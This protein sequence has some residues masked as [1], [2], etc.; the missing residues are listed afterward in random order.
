MWTGPDFQESTTVYWI[1]HI[2]V[3]GNFGGNLLRL[4]AWLNAL[5]RVVP[6]QTP[7][8]MDGRSQGH[9]SDIYSCS[10]Q[11]YFKTKQ[12]WQ[13]KLF[14][15]EGCF[16]C[17]STSAQ[18]AK[19]KHHVTRSI[20]GILCLHGYNNEHN[21]LT[22][23]AEASEEPSFSELVLASLVSRSTHVTM[24]TK[25]LHEPVAAY[26]QIKTIKMEV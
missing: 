2:I 5:F 8:M 20:H 24:N 16:F 7:C 23:N 4:R 10:K 1:C 9:R 22:M 19:R 26:L 11:L 18:T 17:K 21:P 12:A 13:C 15:L 25:M 6:M 14:C 3:S